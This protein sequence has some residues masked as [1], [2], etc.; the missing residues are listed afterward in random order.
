MEATTSK[1]E[2]KIQA[3]KEAPSFPYA[4][5]RSGSKQ[6][7][8]SEGD[9]ILVEKLDVQPGETWSAGDVLFVAPKAGDFQV[10]KP[11]VSGAKVECE[12]LQQALDKKIFIRHSRRR[13][14]SQKSMGHRQ[15][16]TRVLVKK[17]KV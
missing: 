3:W 17:I 14:H 8:V 1:R 11:V 9:Q 4:V 7:C 15:P 5:I 16:L 6:Y 13:H 12:V 10:G 2:E